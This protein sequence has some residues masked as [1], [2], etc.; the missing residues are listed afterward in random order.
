M[1]APVGTGRLATVG[2]G[3]GAGERTQIS[4]VRAVGEGWSGKPQHHLYAVLPHGF[5]AQSNR[6]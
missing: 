4:S 6:K 3:P 2:K 1:P 5:I